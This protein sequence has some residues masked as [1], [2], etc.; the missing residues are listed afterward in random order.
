VA[1]RL[2]RKIKAQ[3]RTRVILENRQRQSNFAITAAVLHAFAKER[4]EI[5]A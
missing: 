4:D 5:E 1:R 3:S 2:W